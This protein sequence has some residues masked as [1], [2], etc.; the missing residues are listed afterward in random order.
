MPICGT[1]TGLSRW[2][3]KAGTFSNVIEVAL[4]SRTAAVTLIRPAGASSVS[5]VTGSVTGT[6]PSL[7][8]TVAVQIVFEPLMAGYSACSMITKPAS[9]SGRVG[10]RTR[11]QQVAG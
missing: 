2:T 8:S 3:A 7:M 4:P 6:S 10:G 11:L 5:S 1:S 9:A